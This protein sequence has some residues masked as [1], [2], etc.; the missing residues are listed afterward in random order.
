MWDRGHCRKRFRV[1]FYFWKN[2]WF[3][4]IGLPNCLLRCFS[5][6]LTLMTW[7]DCFSQWLTWITWDGCFSQWLTGRLFLPLAYLD[8]LGRLFL[9]MAYL[10]NLGRLFLPVAVS[11]LSR[12]TALQAETLAW[13]DYLSLFIKDDGHGLIAH[14]CGR[15]KNDN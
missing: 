4:G 8:N 9:P 1:F 3:S 6:R 11:V 2:G 10:D 5:Q 7:N 14:T 12:H 13:V 15:E